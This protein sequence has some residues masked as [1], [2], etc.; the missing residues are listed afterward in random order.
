MPSYMWNGTESGIFTHGI[1]GT[2]SD[3]ESRQNRIACDVYR[4]LFFWPASM[5][6][7][8]ARSAHEFP[9]LVV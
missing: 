3:E 4:I 6:F 1:W 2:T 5:Y 7:F 8:L 9:R